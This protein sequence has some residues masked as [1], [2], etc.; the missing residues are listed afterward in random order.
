MEFDRDPQA[1]YQGIVF[2]LWGALGVAGIMVMDTPDGSE[3]AIQ[4]GVLIGWLVAVAAVAGGFWLAR[5]GLR[6]QVYRRSA[7]RVLVTLVVTGMLAF[8]AYSGLVYAGI[9]PLP[10]KGGEP[11][12]VSFAGDQLAAPRGWRKDGATTFLHGRAANVIGAE[13]GALRMSE[14]VDLGDQDIVR[15]ITDGMRRSSGA[16]DATVTASAK[17]PAIGGRE[18]RRITGSGTVQ[19]AR[20]VFDI[21]VVQDRSEQVFWTVAFSQ[22]APRPARDLVLERHFLESFSFDAG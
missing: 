5:N 10:T 21:Y 18:A 22:I 17:V 13:I 7:A 15:G 1:A 3:R 16:A 4:Y 2:L 9:V 14:P 19:G 11:E 6:R 20:L 12:T 8:A